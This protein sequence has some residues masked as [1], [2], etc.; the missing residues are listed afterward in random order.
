MKDL[1][2]NLNENFG[3]KKYNDIFKVFKFVNLKLDGGKS[4]GDS[5]EVKLKYVMSNVGDN[6]LKFNEYKYVLFDK[7]QLEIGKMLEELILIRMVQL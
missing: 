1:V 4:V 3:F 2:E 7:I 5:Y 6:F